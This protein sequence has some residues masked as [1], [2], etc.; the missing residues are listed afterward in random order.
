MEYSNRK[1]ANNKYSW[2]KKFQFVDSEK[3]GSAEVLFPVYPNEELCHVE[4]RVHVVYAKKREEL[5]RDHI[6][7]SVDTLVDLKA[8]EEKNCTFVHIFEKRV[9]IINRRLDD[10]LY[11]NVFNYE[12]VDELL[13]FVV[14][15]FQIL[16][17]DPSLNYLVLQ[18]DIVEDSAIAN[19]F[20]IYFKNLLIASNS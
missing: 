2:T 16:D 20:K 6:A 9:I 3:K 11:C 5:Y 10:I 7:A 15:V 4:N 12:S 13:Y 14:A 1:F 18:G 8:C 17:L 19:K